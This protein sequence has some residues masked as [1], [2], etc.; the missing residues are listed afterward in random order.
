MGEIKANGYWRMAKRITYLVLLLMLPLMAVAQ[1]QLMYDQYH[2]LSFYNPSVSNVDGD[3]KHYVQTWAHAAF[4]AKD[5][6]KRYDS[7]LY[8]D[9]NVGARYQGRLDQHFFSA[10]YHY[11]GYSFYHQ[12]TIVLGYAYEFIIKDIHHL[13]IGGRLQVNFCDIMPEKLSFQTD[14]LKSFQMTPDVDLG[15]QYRMRGLH[16]GVSVVN[17]AGNSAANNTALIQYERRGYL[18]LSYDF[19]LDAKKNIILSPHVLFYLGQH[20]ASMDAGINLGLWKYAHVGY[21]FR[22]MEMRHIV[23]AGMEYKGFVLDLA[24]EL[25]SVERKERIQVALG[26]KF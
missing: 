18:N 7:E 6:V 2:D 23:T 13:S 11:D 8:E 5:Y 14:W 17:L 20:T 10:S 24:A 19:A 3:Y 1:D 9:I 21:T 4:A 25:V 16:L 26:Y 15:I 22:V 12:H